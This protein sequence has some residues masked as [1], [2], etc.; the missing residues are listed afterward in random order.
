MINDTLY[1]RVRNLLVKYGA[2]DLELQE[3]LSNKGIQYSLTFID[4]FAEPADIDVVAG[5]FGTQR[6][7]LLEVTQFKD[8]FWRAVF[9]ENWPEYKDKIQL[10]KHKAWKIVCNNEF[11]GAN[12][13][14]TV[15]REIAVTLNSLTDDPVRQSTHCHYP[16]CDCEDRL[17][18]GVTGLMLGPEG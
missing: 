10:P 6:S 3:H 1:T 8:E 7:Y 14:S 17:R 13:I 9:D 16:D 18:C 12:S 2:T 4:A 5:F 15:R 11:R